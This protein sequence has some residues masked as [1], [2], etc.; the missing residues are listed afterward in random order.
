MR[1]VRGIVIAGLLA[2]ASAA[3]ALCAEINL[4]TYPLAIRG[5]NADDWDPIEHQVGF[6]N[7]VDMGEPG[8][9]I[10][11]AFGL[12][13]SI[14]AD[15]TN[16]FNVDDIVGSVGEMSF[17]ITKV[18]ETKGGT[19]PFLSGG[20]SFVSA[21]YQV[22]GFGGLDVDDSDDSLGGWV[23]AGVYWR[24]TSHFNLGLHGRFLGGTSITIFGVEGDADYWQFGPMIGW[25]WPG[26]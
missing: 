4:N 6:G 17:G 19:R 12:H 20:L 25:S 13:A 26:K 2:A 16:S 14:G 23:E 18:W 8:W 15:D 22:N 10:H 21:Y 24:L 7:T 5:L 3:P 1:R 9:P 11:L